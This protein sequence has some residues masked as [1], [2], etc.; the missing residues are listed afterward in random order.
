MVR[1][2]YKKKVDEISNGDTTG[3]HTDGLFFE[4]ICRSGAYGFVRSKFYVDPCIRPEWFF[5]RDGEF[6]F[7]VGEDVFRL[8]A[9]DSIFG[10]RNVP[11]AFA[12]ISDTGRLMIVYQPAGAIEQFFLNA[13]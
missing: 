6:V 7:Q 11:H 10:P 12:N 8:K 13:S 9:G 4:P 2:P 1:G 3:D 5:A